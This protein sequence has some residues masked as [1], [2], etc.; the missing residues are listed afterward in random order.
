M[1]YNP[2]PTVNDPNIYKATRTSGLVLNYLDT[3]HINQVLV[4]ALS[5]L[6]HASRK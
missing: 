6:C 4:I 1:N 5:F 2:E 3:S